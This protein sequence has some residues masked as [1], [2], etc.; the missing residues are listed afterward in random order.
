[1]RLGLEI[2]VL[3]YRLYPDNYRLEEEE[4][5]LGSETVL[6]QIL[7]GEDPAGIVK[8]WQADETHWQQLRK[9]YLL[10]PNP[11]LNIDD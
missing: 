11:E 1:V 9:R 4:N 7:A 10:Y 6:S 5:L 2:A 3:L 8:T